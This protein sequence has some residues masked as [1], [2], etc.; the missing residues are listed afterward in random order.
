MKDYGKWALGISFFIHTIIIAGTQGIFFLKPH[1]TKE[2]KIVNE[3]TLITKNTDEI[4]TTP[5]GQSDKFK[6]PPP[7]IKK[8]PPSVADFKEKLIPQNNKGVSLVKQ[9][10]DKE[11]IQK[12]TL[13]TADSDK[14]LMKIPAYMDYYNSVGEKI[15]KNAY[16]F[17]KDSNNE[18]KVFL[19][20][21]VLPDGRLSELSLN[22]NST[23]NEELRQIAISSVKKAAPFSAFPKEL[24]HLPSLPF[25]VSIHF[26]I[27]K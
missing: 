22:K 12:I 26:R 17:Y 3:I 23:N 8:S 16:L 25:K 5:K 9:I 7:Y 4:R 6:I 10:D 15:R 21:I 18:G 20:C 19:S 24:D 13:D 1:Q 27:T 2:K 14:N 11:P